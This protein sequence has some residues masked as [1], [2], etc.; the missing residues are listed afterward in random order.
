MVTGEEPHP[1]LVVL[2]SLASSSSSFVAVFPLPHPHPLA[3]S[4]LLSCCLF[5]VV[6]EILVYGCREQR[7]PAGTNTAAP[8]FNAGCS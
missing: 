3:P 6:S 4:S 8:L 1:R 7:K 5:F 2:V